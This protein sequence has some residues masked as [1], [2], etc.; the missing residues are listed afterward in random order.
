MIALLAL[1][2][3]TSDSVIAPAYDAITVTV[4]FSTFNFSKA[5]LTASA[6]P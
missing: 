5:F 6:E 2:S 3:K 4:T 1:A